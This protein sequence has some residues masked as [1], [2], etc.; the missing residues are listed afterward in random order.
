M[1]INNIAGE[2]LEIKIGNESDRNSPEKA[3]EMLEW[4]ESDRKQYKESLLSNPEIEP[5]PPELQKF[6]GEAIQVFQEEYSKLGIILPKQNIQVVQGS[7]KFF[8]GE[9]EKRSLQD[10]KGFVRGVVDKYSGVVVINDLNIPD[11]NA[12]EGVA[13]RELTLRY[14]ALIIAHEIYHKLAPVIYTTERNDNHVQFRNWRMGLV[15]ESDIQK[16][17]RMFGLEEGLA[18]IWANKLRTLADKDFP[19]GTTLNNNLLADQRDPGLSDVSSYNTSTET[20][21]LEPVLYPN[22][23]KLVEFLGTKIPNFYKLAE[24]AR[25]NG[26]TGELAGEIEEIFG[27]GSFSTTVSADENNALDLIKK[28]SD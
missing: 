28:L 23:R 22:C 17:T 8:A 24:E 2:G 9:Q 16:G 10:Y 20:A 1:P 11:P 7:D 25:I 13:V 14:K 19:R 5:L 26:K 15:Y 27:I 21:Y 4:L 12:V 18:E 3:I 6:V